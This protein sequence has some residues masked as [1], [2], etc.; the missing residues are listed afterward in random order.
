VTVAGPSDGAELGTAVGGGDLNADGL[1]EWVV[2]APF[3]DR[4]GQAY[5]ILGRTV[6]SATG[7]SGGQHAGHA[8]RRPG[9][10]GLRRGRRHG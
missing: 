8:A 9:R 10:R 6:W 5:R 3:A 7:V 4:T 2:G 1:D